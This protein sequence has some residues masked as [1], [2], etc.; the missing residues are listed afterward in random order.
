MTLSAPIY[1]LK[2]QAKSLKKSTGISHAQALNTLAQKEGYATW[3]LLLAKN[4]EIFPNTYSEILPLLNAGDL[5]LIGARPR[6]GKTI[7]MMGLAA[8]ANTEKRAAVYIFTLVERAEN[9]RKRLSRS[10]K[11]MDADAVIC[12]IDCSDNI[13]ADYIINSTEK[14]IQPGSFVLIDY[15]QV[16]DEKRTNPS[17]QEQINKL[18][19]F[20]KTKRCIIILTSQIK[21]DI[22]DRPQQKP[23]IKDIRLPN[24]LDMQCFNKIFLLS[25]DNRDME[26]ENTHLKRI[27]VHLAAP[28]QHDF[29][30]ICDTENLRFL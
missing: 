29:S 5:V 26:A 2:S 21:R 6:I 27:N 25:P 3:S 24:P 30:V 28:A 16:L 17:L 15:L 20:A 11:K 7:F 18:K 9:I 1:A 4:K 19:Y 23:H 12:E 13:H 22:E 8:Q 10:T 14:T